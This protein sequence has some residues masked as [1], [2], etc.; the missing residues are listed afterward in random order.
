MLAQNTRR[1]VLKRSALAAGA[2]AT[3]SIVPRHVLGGE[4]KTPPSGK[5]NIAGIGLGVVGP[6][7]LAAME[8]ENIVVLCDVDA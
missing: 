2:A 3:I 8:S 7:N 4:D 6:R 5:L 1:E